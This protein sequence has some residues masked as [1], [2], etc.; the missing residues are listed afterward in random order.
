MKKQL[1]TLI[2]AVGILLPLSSAH[3]MTTS[4]SVCTVPAG[5]PFVA[6]STVP[7]GA[8]NPSTSNTLT[9][10]CPLNAPP[11]GNVSWIS[12]LAFDRNTQVNVAC[13]F[14]AWNNSGGYIGSRNFA[15]VGGAVGAGIQIAG[16]SGA[17]FLTGHYHWSARCQI[18]S[19]VVSNGT[20]WMSHIVGFE[21]K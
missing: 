12:M 6:V 5:S 7:Y 13:T 21:L 17:L 14:H 15:T 20:T 10:E 18:P 16:N 3:A 11:D 19:A 8:G 1:A 4:G 9:V 2:A